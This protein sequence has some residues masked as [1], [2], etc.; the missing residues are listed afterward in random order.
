MFMDYDQRP[1]GEKTSVQTASTSGK[2]QKER[3][4]YELCEFLEKRFFPNKGEKRILSTA[5]LITCLGYFD[6]LFLASR[7][8]QIDLTKMMLVPA[9]SCIFITSEKEDKIG[10]CMR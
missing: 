4:K 6:K 10:F 2:E 8:Y 1:V 5:L 3:K 7:T 9:E